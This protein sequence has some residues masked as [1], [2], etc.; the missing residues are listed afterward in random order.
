M[1]HPQL[2]RVLVGL[3]LKSPLADGALAAR[4]PDTLRRGPCR[5][6][7]FSAS[8]AL[9]GRRKHGCELGLGKALSTPL[10]FTEA[11]FDEDALEL[12]WDSNAG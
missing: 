1:H 9:I 10:V 12:S 5:E 2:L 4:P 11:Y 6:P 3:G 8:P 7:G